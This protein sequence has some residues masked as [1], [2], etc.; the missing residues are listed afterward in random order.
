M[1]GRLLVGMLIVIMSMVTA[2]TPSSPSTATNSTNNTNSRKTNLIVFEADSLMVP[3]AQI[4]KEF[5][6]ANPDINVEMQ[7][8]GSIQD[9]RQVTE[10][11]QD[12]D[13]VAVADS[14]LIPMLM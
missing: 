10:L 4:Q 14:S 11:G 5:E 12:V 6:Q 8:H 1:K 13:I 9:I 7:D 2:C 3:F